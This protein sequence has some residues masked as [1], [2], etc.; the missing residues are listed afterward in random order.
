MREG[1][2]ESEKRE[3]ERSRDGEGKV[4]G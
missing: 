4:M 1:P 3:E 2:G